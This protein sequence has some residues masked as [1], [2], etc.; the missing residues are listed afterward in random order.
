MAGWISW[1]S[2]DI[3]RYRRIVKE[4]AAELPVP[5]RRK[6]LRTRLK[7][8]L[9]LPASHR[10]AAEFVALGMLLDELEPYRRDGWTIIAGDVKGLPWFGPMD[11]DSHGVWGVHDAC[12]TVRKMK[13][14][15]PW[16]AWRLLG[17]SNLTDPI[18]S[19]ISATCS[20]I[21]TT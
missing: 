20:V 1:P 12:G 21:I 3:L 9:R 8:Y 14:G 15:A 2:P 18:R 11:S 7:T 6:A 17:R 5:R 4:R 13:R 10:E 16:T 19:T